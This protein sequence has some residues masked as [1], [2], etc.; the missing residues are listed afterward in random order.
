[1]D[2]SILVKEDFINS[3]IDKWIKR[4]VCYVPQCLIEK[5]LRNKNITVNKLK[6]KSSY[7]LKANDKIYLNNFSPVDVNLNNNK[8]YI[9]GKKEIR[10][11]N[12]FI[13]DDNKNFCIIN[14]PY[15]LA[16]QGGSKINKNLVDLI[17]KNS[18]FS[19]SKPF[20]V[21]RIDKE[22]SGILIIAKNRR[23]AQLFTSLFRIR[24]IHKSYLSICY[25][26]MEKDKGTFDDNLVR[27]EKSK[28]ISERAIT[29]YKVV[30]KNTNTTLLAL[31]PITGRKHQIRKQLFS[32]GFPVI[33]DSK[34]NF[35]ENKIN[36]NKNLMLH[37]YSIKFMINEKKYNYTVNVPD[38]FNKMLL[39]K[40]LTL[41]KNS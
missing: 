15:G 37:A 3:R 36:Q 23:Y 38:Y 2:K 21:H 39:A 31:N 28:K 35:P 30:D 33:G 11:S 12:A 25:G 4:N 18:I 24:K 34:Y 22:T 14:K 1:M 10:D 32:I 29:H 27:Y 20:I 9:P 19:N 17:T 6:V 8:K 5:S 41:F 13:V 7:K 26:E 40:R 16:V